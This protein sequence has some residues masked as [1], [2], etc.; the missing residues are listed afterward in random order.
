MPTAA[1]ISAD[2]I[3]HLPA[4]ALDAN[5]GNNFALT[6]QRDR[7]MTAV[8]FL[9]LLLSV[10]WPSLEDCFGIGL[11]QYFQWEHRCICGGNRISHQRSK[12][13]GHGE[14]QVFLLDWMLSKTVTLRLTS[15]VA[16]YSRIGSV[17]PKPATLVICEELTPCSSNL[18]RTALA[19]SEE[20]SQSP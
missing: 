11:L 7:R 3:D 10:F 16:S 20:I 2:Q 1:L 4:R 9:L 14:G 15:L 19:R 17:S 6:L 5:A 18:R 8:F 12:G 13:G